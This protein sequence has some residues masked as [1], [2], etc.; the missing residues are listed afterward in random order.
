MGTNVVQC[1]DCKD[2]NWEGVTKCHHCGSK[3][4]TIGFHQLLNIMC[5]TDPAFKKEIDEIYNKERELPYRG[6]YED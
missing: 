2:W 5:I 4:L 6:G 1:L 3:N